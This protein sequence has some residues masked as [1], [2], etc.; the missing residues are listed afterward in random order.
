METFPLPFT[1]QKFVVMQVKLL[2]EHKRTLIY[3]PLA[4]GVHRFNVTIPE[5]VAITDKSNFHLIYKN[6]NRYYAPWLFNVRMVWLDLPVVCLPKIS[7]DVSTNLELLWESYFSY[8]PTCDN[9]FTQQI[10][11]VPYQSLTES[12]Q[13]SE[14]YKLGGSQV[15]DTTKFFIESE[16]DKNV[17]MFKAGFEIKND[18]ILKHYGLYST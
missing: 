18:S 5:A 7:D 17:E 1:F 8:S 12:T 9:W 13:F 16:Y 4:G 6:N 2:A 11:K 15:L 10:I 3:K 14:A